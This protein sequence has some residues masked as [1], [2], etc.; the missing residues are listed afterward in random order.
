M[1]TLW[2]VRPSVRLCDRVRVGVCMCIC[3]VGVSVFVY[4][5]VCVCEEIESVRSC[6]CACQLITRLLAKRSVNYIHFVSTACYSCPLLI[7]PSPSS[8]LY[9][10]RSTIIGSFP[11]KPLHSPQT[12]DHRP[13]SADVS[14]KPSC[15]VRPQPTVGTASRFHQTPNWLYDWQTVSLTNSRE[16]DRCLGYATRLNRTLSPLT[17]PA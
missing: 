14:P 5:W 7:S 16:Y 2:I 9:T 1:S 17:H 13:T 10:T 12:Y 3:L 6:L 15:W 4:V 8:T 11:K